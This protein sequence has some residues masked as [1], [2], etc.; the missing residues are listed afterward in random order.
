TGA[1]GATGTQGPTG[2][3]GATGA[4]G[5]RGPTGST[6]TTGATGGAGPTGSTGTTGATGG[7]GPTGSTGSTGATGAQGPSGST[8]STGPVGPN[9]VSLLWE[10]ND[11]AGPN[12]WCGVMYPYLDPNT[13]ALALG[14]IVSLN[15]AS[16]S[17]EIFFTPVANKNSWFNVTGGNLGI[18]TTGPAAKLAIMVNANA[19]RLEVVSSNNT[20][21]VGIKATGDPEADNILNL[22]SGGQVELS[23]GTNNYQLNILAGTDSKIQLFSAGI[24]YLAGGNVGIGTTGPAALLD[25]AGGD[26]T[27]G[28]GVYYPSTLSTHV[29]QTSYFVVMDTAGS[30]IFYTSAGAYGVAGTDFA[31]VFDTDGVLEAGDVVEVLEGSNITDNRPKVGKSSTPVSQKLIGVISDRAAFIGG[32]KENDGDVRNKTVG[33]LGRIPIKISD[34][35]GPIKLGDPLTSST[36]AGVAVKAVTTGPIIARALEEYD[37]Q[38]GKTGTDGK[39]LAMVQYSWFEPEVSLNQDGNMLISGS[40]SLEPNNVITD[41]TGQPFYNLRLKSGQLLDKSAAYSQATIANINS[42]Y[43]KAQDLIVEGTTNLQQGLQTSIVTA[44]QL[45]SETAKIASAQ[46]GILR[47]ETKLI[48]PLIETDTLKA[49]NIEATG[50]AS[51]NEIKTNLLSPLSSDQDITIDLASQGE[52]LQGSE[53]G[54]LIIKGQEDQTVASIDSAGNASFSGQLS[55][56][57]V[58]SDLGNL[59]DLNVS[60]DT[61]VSGT[62]HADKIESTDLNTLKSNFGDLLGKINNLQDKIASQSITIIS[63][64][65]TLEPAFSTPTL[66]PLP[67]PSPTISAE[68][69]VSTRSA[70]WNFDKANELLARLKEYLTSSS[71]LAQKSDEFIASSSAV[72]A[73]NTSYQTATSIDLPK[74]LQLSSLKVTD[75]TSLADTSIAGSLLVDGSIIIENNKIASIGDKLY[76]S[77]LDTVDILGGKLIVDNSGNLTVG[78]TL[79]AKGGIATD[80]IKSING[81]IT[82]DLSNDD[83]NT[84]PDRHTYSDPGSSYINDRIGGFGKLLI[85]GENDLTVSSI[86]SGGNAT[87][88]GT[89]TAEKLNLS[90]S[91]SDLEDTKGLTLITAADN[92]LQNGINAPAV[93]TDGTAGTATLLSGYNSLVIFN[94]NITD[95]TLIYITPTSPTENRTLFVANKV[96]G[97]YFTVSLD[98]AIPHDVRF[99]W[100]IIN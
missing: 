3:T 95:N 29:R 45:V 98:T 22:Q 31:E 75:S 59:G 49:E 12:N 97:R 54:K 56:S 26:I 19:P 68:T 39:I 57:S 80:E 24:S 41:N 5:S 40:E 73:Q 87:F 53:S 74:D 34:L 72:I 84:I 20:T 67:T 70:S 69:D 96:P 58:I 99:N 55:S 37:P 27:H 71:S 86:D 91:G 1:T 4:T 88:S 43:I 18:G 6:G 11:C 23:D 62:L 44:K 79:I 32:K 66:T 13:Q 15:N 47:V 64:T 36:I 83:A 7:A 93:K 100:W 77:S 90:K 48:S 33:L 9:G 30:G 52:T 60:G 35:N 94:P 2:T 82:I 14:E 89:L 8:G 92:F 46:I 81:D 10:A 61:T 17:A 51:L 38:N 16:S 28:G 65:P 85:K 78:G 25:V 63:P 21:K 76:L 42:G 50:T